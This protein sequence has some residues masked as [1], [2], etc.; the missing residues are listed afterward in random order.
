MLTEIE[1]A[2]DALSIEQ[3]QELFLFLAMRL[4]AEGGQLPEPRKFSHE[5]MTG[6]IKENE[7][8]MRRFRE[9]K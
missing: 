2:A 1:T 3:K 6:W 4:R 7:A 8:D 5:Q 9:A